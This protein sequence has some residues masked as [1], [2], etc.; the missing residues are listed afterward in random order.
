MMG[1]HKQALPKYIPVLGQPTPP[2]TQLA[3]IPSPASIN[4]GSSSKPTHLDYLGHP[5]PTVSES[6]QDDPTTISKTTKKK[7]TTTLA[8]HQNILVSSMGTSINLGVVDPN[9]DPLDVNTDIELDPVNEGLVENA[10]VFV[11]TP[12]GQV[13]AYFDYQY[14]GEVYTGGFGRSAA[15]NSAAERVCDLII[16]VGL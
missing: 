3:I 2:G 12:R 1:K 15:S 16:E 8:G 11:G 14:Q 10:M 5:N 9:Q 4:E 13:A 7:P 6:H